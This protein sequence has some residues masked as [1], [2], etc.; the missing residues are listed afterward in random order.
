A[1]RDQ[2][3]RVVEDRDVV[4]EVQ[5]VQLVVPDAERVD[6]ER[7]VNRELPPRDRRVGEQGVAQGFRRERRDEVGLGRTSEREQKETGE[8]DA[9]SLASHSAPP[10][11]VVSRP[12]DP[13]GM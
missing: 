6:L 10:T 13:P 5:S 12:T 8:P 3:P 1:A 11:I 4:R 2:G 7:S 9:E